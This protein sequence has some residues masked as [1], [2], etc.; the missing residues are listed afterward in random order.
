MV[1]P[2]NTEQS[3]SVWDNVED[4][5]G[6]E[7]MKMSVNEIKSRTR[8]LDNEVRVSLF[9]TASS[10]FIISTFCQSIIK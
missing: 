4:D 7:I 9:E 5:L 8:L 1:P 10:Y 6:E 3:D 2:A